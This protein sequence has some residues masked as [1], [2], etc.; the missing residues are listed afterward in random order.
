[1]SAISALLCILVCI[2]VMGCAQEHSQVPASMPAAA[3]PAAAVEKGLLNARDFGAKGDGVADDTAALQKALDAAGEV[4]GTVYVPPGTYLCADLK[5]RPLTGLR[6]EATYSYRDNSGTILKLNS[7]QAKCLLNLTGAH[8][9]AVRD[10]CLDG[11]KRMGEQVHGIM[12]NK[13]DYGQQEDAVC[14]DHCRVSNFSGHGVL[15]ERIWCFSV[16][17][18]MIAH[19]KGNGIRLRGWDG[20]VLDN[21]LSGNGS[22]GLGAYDENASNTITANRIEWNATA[23]IDIRGGNEYNIT[24]NYIDRSGG[25]GIRL[26]LRD[27][28]KKNPCDHFSVT[29]NVIYRSGA[30]NW[31]PHEPREDCHILLDGCKGVVCTGNC[32]AAGRDDGN[33][34]EWSPKFGLVL[35][36]LSNSIVKDNA[37]QD[38]A[39]EK[40]IQ[41]EGEHDANTIIKDNVGQ[42]RVLTAEQ[43]K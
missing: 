38:G 14:I 32:M 20:F 37:M 3:A 25:P 5:M 26:G 19:N 7:P 9:A 2:G 12:V 42:L 4:R 21:W 23:G 15:L 35:H 10:V 43:K 36:K 6:G 29:G 22:A 13:P 40:L 24:G 18:C 28:D 31:G 17:H 1:M 11:S 8:G 33:K 16:R 39:L 30:T 41:D 34:G 27:N